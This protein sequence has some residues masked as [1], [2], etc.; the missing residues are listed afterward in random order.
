M[1]LSDQ[2]RSKFS[3]V[4]CVGYPSIV[5]GPLTVYTARRLIRTSEGRYV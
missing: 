4:M 2:D 1:A 3:G 5:A